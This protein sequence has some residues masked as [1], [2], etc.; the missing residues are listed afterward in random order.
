MALTTILCTIPFF[1]SAENLNN[2]SKN[3]LAELECTDEGHYTG[4]MGDSRVYRLDKEPFVG[5]SPYG[6]TGSAGFNGTYKDGGDGTV[7]ENGLEVFLA[8]W[9]SGDNISWAY[10]TFKLGKQ[11]KNLSGKSEL[12]CSY[13]NSFD[14]TAYFYNGDELLYS[15]N[16]TPNNYKTEFNIDVSNV[17]ELK[18]LIKDNI[19]TAGGTSFALYDLFLDYHNDSEIPEDAVEF[20]GH[21]YKVYNIGM[22]WAKA[23]EYCENRGGHLVTITSPEENAFVNNLITPLSKSADVMIGL[24]DIDKEGDWTTWCTGEPVVYSNWGDNEPD[25]RGGGQDI[26]VIV[27]GTRGYKGGQ[28]YCIKGQWDDVGDKDY[29]L[30][31]ICEW[32]NNSALDNKNVE[33]TKLHV[34]KTLDLSGKENNETGTWSSSDETVAKVSQYGVVSAIKKGSATITRTAKSETVTVN[35]SVCDNSTC[36]WKVTEIGSDYREG[37]RDYVCEICGE[38]VTSES[39]KDNLRV[40]I[41]SSNLSYVKGEKIYIAVSDFVFTKE[42]KPNKLSIVLSGTSVIE[43]TDIKDYS[44]MTNMK[45]KL[46]EKC[47]ILV[48]EAKGVGSAWISLTNEQTRHTRRIPIAVSED[49]Y[50]TIRADKVKTY[51]YKC[52]LKTD[53]YNA[54]FDGIWVSDFSCSEADGGWNFSMNIYNENYSNA[55]LEVFDKD[56]KLINVKIIDKF[57]SL[58]KGLK[59]TVE[60]GWTVIEDAIDGDSL[61]FRADTISKHTPIKN[62]KIPQD[63]FIRITADSSVSPSC[64]VVNAFDIAL[65][66]WTFVSD[67]SQFISGISKFDRDSAKALTK[68]ALM[69]LMAQEEYLNFA[70]KFQ[71]KFVGKLGTDLSLDMLIN[72]SNKILSDADL[73][74]FKGLDVDFN[75]VVKMALGT[76]AGVAEGLFLK[77]SGPYGAVLKSMFIFQDVSDWILEVNNATKSITGS[78][79][80]GWMTP[81]KGTSSAL[82]LKNEN[83]TVD[84]NGNVPKDVIMQSFR[85]ARGNTYVRDFMEFINKPIEDYETYEIALYNDGNVVQPE[86][87]VEVSIVSPYKSATVYRQN[88]D[89]TWERIE[90]KMKNGMVVFEVDHFCKFVIAEEE[91]PENP[92][93]SC[94]CACHKKGIVKFFFKIGLFFQKIFKKNKI[95]KCGA[96]HY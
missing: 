74:L 58:T 82:V 1:A 86:G 12:I 8:R 88:A 60:A 66:C 57:E 28:F 51:D 61:S 75:D 68:T 43:V 3:C 29:K 32:E 30:P 22:T 64:A 31:F 85:I 53:K 19:K 76:G 7:Y 89:G 91:E 70:K 34:G 35:V 15:F 52:W 93:A 33:S 45:I 4:N 44:E 21:Y 63:G 48:L 95:C 94:S 55:V 36:D 38:V 59:K 24:S 46:F 73:L 78:N 79:P 39:F 42:Y 83:V 10:R 80:I 87:K 77:L 18:V 56:G 11:Y 9:I 13:K 96:Q 14:V 37:T 2:G 81:Y 62:L 50:E 90:S 72:L 67:I 25:N 71:D 47:K 65:T 5:V 23:K 20:N 6:Y 49:K 26:C 16:M 92:S 84:T 40:T 41:N 54:S 17:D 27:N 69:K